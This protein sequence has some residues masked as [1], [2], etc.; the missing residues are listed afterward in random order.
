M[1]LHPLP[2]VLYAVYDRSS[3]LEAAD[4]ELARRSPFV[5]ARK[6]FELVL[7]RGREEHT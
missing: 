6:M 5:E 4:V 2:D 3:D 7:S 1:Q